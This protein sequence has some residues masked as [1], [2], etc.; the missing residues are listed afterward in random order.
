MS[1]QEDNVDGAEIER[2]PTFVSGLDVIL[3]GGFLRGGLYMI[4]GR[5]GAGKT[6]LASEIVF[7]RAKEGSRT[8]YV[9]MMGEN[10]GRMMAHLHPMH[11]FDA[12]FVPDNVAYLS[13]Y[14]VLEDEDLDGLS[15]LLRREVL[16]RRTTLLVLD[17]MAAD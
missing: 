15:T 14:K 3:C 16:A 7:N 6:T 5:P 13:A 8:L 2:F 10:H 1:Q 11:F 4:Q 9:T 17:G 12:T